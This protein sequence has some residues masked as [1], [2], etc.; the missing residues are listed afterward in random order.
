MADEPTIT[1]PK[2]GADIKLTESLAAPIL[3]TARQEFAEQLRQ[4]D[5]QIAERERKLKEEHK[6][7]A[8]AK[9]QLDDAVE[10][11]LKDE[12]ES[13]ARQEAKRARRAMED[14][15]AGKSKELSELK[16]LLEQ[17]NEKLASAQKAQAELLKKER[18]LEDAKREMELTI[19]K[20]L[21]EELDKEREK[22]KKDA[23]EEHRLKLAEKEKQI[24]DLQRNIEE[25]KRKAEQGSQQLQGEVQELDLEQLLAHKFPIDS[26]EPVAKGVRG[27]DVLQRVRDG[28]AQ[29]CG[30]IL[31]ESKR[32]KNWNENWL[33]KLRSDQRDANADI[34]IIVSETL[35]EGLTTFESR[36]GVIIVARQCV[37]PVAMLVRQQVIEVSSARQTGEGQKTKMELLYEYLMGPQFRHRVEAIVEAFTTMRNDLESEKR[38]VQ[39]Q[40]AK[41]EKQIEI[42]T[43]STVG[44]WGDLQGIAGKTLQEIDGLEVPLLEDSEVRDG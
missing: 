9:E 34:A 32:A 5:A 10:A 1:C 37:L 38:S 28:T 42:V 7:L 17:K 4:R 31:W 27:A 35:P 13:I 14:E 12:R 21:G 43:Q 36:D 8:Q 30:S 23:D 6:A 20:R 33:A 39:R 11:R 24:A 19:Q 15:L 26:I 29:E 18:E 16:T 44:M 41:R 40:W 3:E 2:C 25:W 22:A